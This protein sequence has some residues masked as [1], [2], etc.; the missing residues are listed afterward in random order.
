MNTMI[1]FL[2]GLIL[3]GVLGVVVLLVLAL[4][5]SGDT[6]D[7]QTYDESLELTKEEIEK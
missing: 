2:I 5:A 4:A 3:G 1:S 7:D 6:F